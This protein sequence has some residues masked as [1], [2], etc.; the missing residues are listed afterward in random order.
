MPQP[1][2]YLSSNWPLAI[3]IGRPDLTGS[4]TA[5][6]S[7]T[8]APTKS[9]SNIGPIVGGVIGGLAVVLLA[10]VYFTCRVVKK[11]RQQGA[12]QDNPQRKPPTP[13][14]SVSQQSYPGS[15]SPR[16]EMEHMRSM[17]DSSM[18]YLD[19]TRY[20]DIT[21]FSMPALPPSTATMSV[22]PISPQMQL[23]TAAGGVRN[24]P[25]NIAPTAQN[26]G[27]GPSS[28]SHPYPSSYVSPASPTAQTAQ[29]SQSHL[30]PSASAS[31]S[32]IGFGSLVGGGSSE[33]R[34]SHPTNDPSNGS[35][36]VSRG[37][38]G[39]A[40]HLG[41]APSQRGRLNPPMYTTN[42][43][44]GEVQTMAPTAP[45][46]TKM[47]QVYQPVVMTL[48]SDKKEDVTRQP[49]AVGRPAVVP[50]DGRYQEAEEPEI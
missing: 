46:D 47:K 3:P 13:S 7:S 2:I 39:N 48:Q 33:R 41:S 44:S 49:E 10:L 4:S 50:A 28:V 32:Q 40:G 6:P 14:M 22:V 19:P 17:S 29:S 1:P 36:S 18:A 9:S 35:P 34:F 45:D 15:P 38:A 8:P 27:P 30:P 43:G 42:P 31:A 16:P 25:A 20:A 24:Y 23:V 21:P 11:R 37:N 5:S 12:Q 26:S